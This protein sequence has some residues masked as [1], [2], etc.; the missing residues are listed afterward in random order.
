MQETE[1][2]VKGCPTLDCKS[3]SRNQRAEVG[4]W[5]RVKERMRRK[6]AHE[7]WLTVMTQNTRKEKGEGY[8]VGGVKEKGP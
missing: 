7:S 1:G 8:G 2:R 6:A 3:G 4:R 5:E